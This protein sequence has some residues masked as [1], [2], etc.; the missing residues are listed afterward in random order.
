LRRVPRL[1]GFGSN[2][3]LA[4]ILTIRFPVIAG[5]GVGTITTDGGA[6]AGIAGG[7]AMVMAGGAV[8]S[9]SVIGERI[10]SQR[11]GAGCA[12]GIARGQRPG[13]IRGAG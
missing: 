12:S 7:A 6:G 3:T 9:N 10:A 11:R 4:T 13:L 5:A 1:R 8:E 2:L